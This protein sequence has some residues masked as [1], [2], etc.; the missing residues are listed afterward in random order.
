MSQL[1][2]PVNPASPPPPPSL[3]AYPPAAPGG[4][5]PPQQ[6]YPGQQQPMMY[7]P[8]PAPVR[9][10]SVWRSLLRVRIAVILVI[11]VVGGI[12]AA[13]RA[14]NGATHGQTSDGVI[15]AG[16]CVKE[17]VTQVI[18]VD[19]SDTHTGKVST[20]LPAGTA[21]GCPDGQETV[22]LKD[23]TSGDPVGT[24]CIDTSG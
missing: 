22:G 17:T 6:A 9:R 11:V 13:V 20:V 24:A 3:P 15:V 1:P 2:P 7:A 4:Y 14:Y 18:R 8:A 23:P 21:S 12:A 19:C 5:V 16:D 10:R